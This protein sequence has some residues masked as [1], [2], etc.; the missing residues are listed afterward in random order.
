MIA[1]PEVAVIGG[2]IAGCATA[3]FLAEAGAAVT[4]YEREATGAGASGRNSGIIQ[5][6]M[7]EALVGLYEQSLAL[8]GALGHGFELPAEPSGVL[9]VSEDR[10][11][12]ARDFESARARFP[13]LEPEWIEADE[14]LAPG[15]HAY[16][17]NTGREIGP[18]AATRAW[19]ERAR[20]AGARFEIGVEARAG[21]LLRSAGVVVVAAGPWTPEALGARPGWRPVYANWGVIAEVRL[22]RP[23]RHALEQAGIEALTAPGGA[24]G[25]LFSLVTTGG[26]SA[27]GSTFSPEPPDAA[28]VAPAV[29]EHAARFLPAL[30]GARI[31]RVRACARPLSADGRPLLG[32]VA[33]RVHLVTG[34]GAWGV[35]L[36]P[37]SAQAVAQA[38]L[39]Q[40]D[41]IP[42]ELAAARFGEP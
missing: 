12:L 13:G 16:R 19:A 29:L 15:I 32:A 10:D 41:A 8:Y 40:A 34:H 27:V 24:A 11:A 23:P 22:A 1:A 26:V 36:G 38:V 42:P 6:P 9:L 5:H 14:E 28:A 37:A 30:A 7:D 21:D 20:V 35:T 33:D 2:G 17:L 39:G 4:L 31:E 18:T 25:S 3:A